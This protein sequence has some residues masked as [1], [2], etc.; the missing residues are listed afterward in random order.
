MRAEAQA[1]ATVEP[2]SRRSADVGAGTPSASAASSKRVASGRAIRPVSFTPKPPSELRTRRRPLVRLALLWAAFFA[3]AGVT[4]FIF[5]AQS[6]IVDVRPAPDGLRLEGRL[7]AIPLGSRFLARPGSYRILAEKKGY[8]ALEAGVDVVSGGTQRFAFVLEKLP[9]RVALATTPES[10]V[11]VRVDGRDVGTTPLEPIELSAGEHGFVLRAKRHRDLETTVIVEGEGTLVR[12]EAALE[13]LWAPVTFRSK[14]AGASIWLGGKSYGETPLTIDLL[15]GL[16]H[17][18]ARRAGHKTRRGRVQVTAGVARTVEIDV[19][20]PAD[21]TLVVESD[22]SDAVLMLDGT[23]VGRTP[24]TLDVAPGSHEIVVSLSGHESERRSVSVGSGESAELEVSLAPRLGVVAIVSDPADA[25]LYV[26][27]EALGIVSDSRSLELPAREHAIEIRRSGYETFATRVTPRPGFPQALEVALARRADLEPPVPEGVLR[28]IAGQELRR[29]EPNRF[30]MGASR[31]EPGRRANETLRDVEITRAFYLS[32]TEVSNAEYRAFDPSH[33][34]GE[35]GGQSLD[36][37]GQPVVRVTWEQAAAYCNWLSARE[38]LPPAYVERD[39]KLALAEP[40]TTGY[41]LPTEAEWALSARH[42]NGASSALKYPW[43]QELPVAPGSGNYA[44][45]S[46]AGFLAITLPGYQDS[47]PASAPVTSATPSP[48]GFRHLGGNVAE[49]V[50]DFYSIPPASS[51]TVERD[52]RGPSD[53]RHRVIRGASFM[54]G[55]VTRLRLSY[56]DYG[57]GARPDVG[58]RIARHVE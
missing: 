56:R 22:P 8:Q 37:E 28:T 42:P 38:S 49:W 36:G 16:H 40:M 3:L 46:A 55:S 25:E 19:L 53:G 43:G 45:D 44:D 20:A 6:V 13:P 47:F 31:R 14:P 2:A 30:Q 35:I 21:G 48:G 33:R 57:D 10:G 58:F 52:P 54:D 4:W 1:N 12:V 34:S 39:G 51:S 50:N 5:T 18:E 15:E 23:F 17:Y 41:R 27:G 26:D 9:G 11:S 32:T 7:P 29:V 24:M